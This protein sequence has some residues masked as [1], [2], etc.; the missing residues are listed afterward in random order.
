MPE[1]S[2]FGRQDEELIRKQAQNLLNDYGHPWDS[3]AEGVQNAVDAVNTRYKFHL[4]DELNVTFEN[5][6]VWIDEAA[7]E[8][9]EQDKETYESNYEVWA[10]EDYQ[11]AAQDRWY[12][13]LGDIADI[14]PEEIEAADISVK[15]S[16]TAEIEIERIQS[17]RTLRIRD[18]GIGMSFEELEYAVLKGGSHKN[19]QT[20]TSEIGELGNGLTYQICSCNDF[21]IETSDG[22]G[23]FVDSIDD[24]HNWIVD[25]TGVA[26]EDQPKSTPEQISDSSQ[27]RYTEVT[28]GGIRKVS[29]DFPDIFDDVMTVDRFKHLIRTKTAIGHLYESL[30]YPVFDTLSSDNI[31]VTFIETTGMGSESEEVEFRYHGPVQIANFEEPTATTL[32]TRDEARE[33]VNS[34]DNIGG[35]AIYH[36]GVFESSSGITLYYLAFV[37]SR[38]WYKKASHNL[39]LCDNAGGSLDEMGDYDVRSSLELAVKGM[40]TAVSVS[41]PPEDSLG[42]WLN[43]HV[44]IMDNRLKFDEGRKS[45]VGRRKALY[46]NCAHE[47][48]YQDITTSLLR[49]AIKDPTVQL[50]V[51]QMGQERQDFISDNTTGRTALSFNSVPD[52][53]QFKNEPEEEQDLVA[54]FHELIAGGVIPYYACEAASSYSVYD[55]IFEYEVPLDRIGRQYRM[56]ESDDPLTE[57]VVLEYK[58][59]GEDLIDDISRHQKFYYMMD[60]LVCW[61]IDEEACHDAGATL[62]DKS[63]ESTKYWGTT[64]ELVLEPMHFDHLGS[65]R[66][67]NIIVLK[68][69]LSELEDDTYALAH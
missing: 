2:L 58:L 57:H 36:R 8:V 43:M 7:D 28:M 23:V 30:G 11:D 20:Q 50:N 12:E 64:H 53:I 66:Q 51:T 6:E 25:K 61:D 15:D 13:I 14:P 56:Q 59:N 1:Q 41:P 49:Q 65:G 19:D 54:L 37:S 47:A 48:L 32:L 3:L 40:P 4:A 10:S 24:M 26:L 17:T 69:L 27:E 38:D 29:S 46:R 55:A 18:N 21:K 62:I 44:V 60:L 31:D 34:N 22:K 33:R 63:P 39:A 42:Y 68:Q 52:D 9:V 5:L 45:V 67:L 35:S 16:Y